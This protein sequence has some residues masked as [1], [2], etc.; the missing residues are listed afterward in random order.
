MTTEKL[1]MTPTACL[2]PKGPLAPSALSHADKSRT[3]WL[4]DCRGVRRM[5]TIQLTAD[6]EQAPISHHLNCL[7][8]AQCYTQKQLLRTGAAFLGM[9][10]IGG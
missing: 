7:R 1:S 2:F 5:Q 8:M 10:N 3:L 6:C 4:R 9:L